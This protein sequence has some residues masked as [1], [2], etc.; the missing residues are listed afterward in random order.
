MSTAGQSSMPNAGSQ[1]NGHAGAPQNG[2]QQAGATA[3]E[4]QG[5][6]QG[7]LGQGQPARRVNSFMV[8]G[9]RFDVDTRYTLV[10][11]IGHGAYGVVRAAD[12]KAVK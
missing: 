1:Q 5:Q 4:G 2:Q 11:P 9:T 3:R 12:G 7:Q 8:C 10:K 6:G